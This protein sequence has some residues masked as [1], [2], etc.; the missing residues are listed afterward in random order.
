MHASHIILFALETAFSIAEQTK[1]YSFDCSRPELIDICKNDC[2]AKHCV[3]GTASGLL[4]YAPD[5]NDQNRQ[6]SDDNHSGL[7]HPCRA[8]CGWNGGDQNRNTIEEYPFAITNEGGTYAALRCASSYGQSGTFSS[9]TIR[10][11][12]A[13]IVKFRVGP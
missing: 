1:T 12:C 6:L 11:A 5:R 3:R 9:R 2:W 10:Y 13:N 8:Q 7:P 4:T